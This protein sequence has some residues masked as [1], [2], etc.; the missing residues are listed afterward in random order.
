MSVDSAAAKGPSTTEGALPIPRD[1][2]DVSNPP[3]PE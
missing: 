3:S 2:A 1:L